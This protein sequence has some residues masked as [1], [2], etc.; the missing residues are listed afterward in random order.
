MKLYEISEQFKKVEDLF[1]S[2]QID[3]TTFNDTMQ[4]IDMEFNDKLRNCLMIKS[5]IES[6]II[7]ISCEIQR[8]KSLVEMKEKNA[9]GLEDYIKLNMEASSKDKID[10]GIFKVTLRA[11]TKA[12]KVHDET[13]IPEQYFRVIPEKREPDKSM[14]TQALK[15]GVEIEGAELVDGKRGLIIK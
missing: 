8:L 14:I 1:D 13:K 15:N 2:G 5:G 3:E 4:S 10:L 12:L 6:D 7:A 9:Q 11:P